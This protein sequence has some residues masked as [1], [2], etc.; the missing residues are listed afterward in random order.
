MDTGRSTLRDVVVPARAHFAVRLARGQ[1]LRVVDVEGQQVLD[2]V[3]FGAA[4]PREKLSCILSNLFNGTWRLTTGHVLYTNR[5]QPMLTIG[6]DRVGIHHSGGGFCSEESNFFRYRVRPTPNCKANL[7]QA[8]A[9]QGIPA[10]VLDYDAC[11]NVFM[12]IEY[13]P[14]GGF[15]I[16]PPRSKAG[17]HVD[18]VAEMDCLLALSNC[19]QERNP[20]NGYRPTP[21]R[22]VIRDRA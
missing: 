18:L 15:A 12:N 5:A 16:A 3:A 19:P 7:E 13:L 1:A 6:D 14:D 2:L 4:D 10:D 9:E 17:D 8:M 21:L 20:C 22:L 11:F